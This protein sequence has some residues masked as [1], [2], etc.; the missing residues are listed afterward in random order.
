MRAIIATDFHGQLRKL[1]WLTENKT[2]ISAGI[3]EGIPD[4]HATYHADG[5][6]HHKLTN[7]DNISYRYHLDKRDQPDFTSNL[8]FGHQ[9]AAAQTILAAVSTQ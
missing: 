3:C 8:Q 6:Y 4:P 9:W 1:V 5:K 2:G 7:K